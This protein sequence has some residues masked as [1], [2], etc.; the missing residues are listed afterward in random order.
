MFCLTLTG[1]NLICTQPRRISATSVASRVAQERG[2]KIGTSVGY[3]IRLESVHSSSTKILFVTT[4]V[5]LR[6]LAE[7]PL[8][9]G[10]RFFT[11][12]SSR[13]GN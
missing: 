3:K 4:G 10:V 5:L 13:T 8:L 7:D 6:R 9:A 11:F 1:C 12:I 2:E